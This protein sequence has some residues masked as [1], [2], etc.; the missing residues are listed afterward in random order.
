MGSNRLVI[1]EEEMNSAVTGLD[2]C[3]IDTE[4]TGK[5]MSTK[6]AVLKKIGLFG[7]GVDKINKQINSLSK[8]LFNVKNIV[9][10]NSNEMF[11]MDRQLAYIAEDIEIPQDFT[12]NN[13]MFTTEFNN[14]IMSKNDGRAVEEGQPLSSIPQ[15][16]STSSIEQTTLGNINNQ[17]S[18]NQVEYNNNILGTKQ[19]LGNINNNQ[20]TTEQ[21]LREQ[22]STTKTNIG[23]INNN[24][25]IAE[26]QLREQF[27]TT[28]TNIGN[29]NNNES[30]AEQQLTESFN[31]IKSNSTTIENIN[32]PGTSIDEQFNFSNDI[33]NKIGSQQNIEEK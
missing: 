5:N 30:I 32:D 13:S 17:E 24:Q 21:Q 10:K 4:N 12:K 23:N 11:E 3:Y 22:F 9:S 31:N 6:F 29:I 19:E 28:K 2:K 18:T 14:M 16:S 8:S 7:D 25:S 15:V 26:Q 1:R 20:S 33:H 27:S